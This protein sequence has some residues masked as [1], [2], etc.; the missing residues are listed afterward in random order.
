[1][2]AAIKDQTEGK[3][4]QIVGVVVDFEFPEGSLP[5]I[6]G[7]LWSLNSKAKD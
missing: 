1:M 2:S 5:A 3:V 4:S 6:Y 7:M